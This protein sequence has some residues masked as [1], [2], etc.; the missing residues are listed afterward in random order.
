MV[1]GA[2]VGGVGVV[3]IDIQQAGQDRIDLLG[4]VQQLGVE[5]AA[6][7]VDLIGARQALHALFN[8]AVLTQQAHVLVV[9]VALFGA[10]DQFFVD[11]LGCAN[12]LIAQFEGFQGLLL[13][14]WL[15]VG[16]QAVRQH[17]QAQGQLGEFI[18]G[19]N[20]GHAGRGDVFGGC[21]N[22]AH[23]VQGEHTEQQHQG[24]N[25]REAKEG[26]RGDIHITKRHAG[27][28]GEALSMRP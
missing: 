12:L 27:V 8:L 11:V 16:Q 26:P 21:T 15:A 3:V 6:Q 10:G 24:A 25:K 22:F 5:Q 4:V 1:F 17:A 9:S 14:I 7:L 20:A 23:L 13:Y 2:L 28:L 19:A 18:Q